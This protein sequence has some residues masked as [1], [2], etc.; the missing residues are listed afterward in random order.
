[1]TINNSEVWNQFVQAANGSNLTFNDCDIYGSRFTASD[2]SSSINV[3]NS[4]LYENPESCHPNT[5]INIATGQP[6]CNPFNKPGFPKIESIGPV[7][8]DNTKNCGTV[9]VDDEVIESINEI[10][11]YPNPFAYSTT[12]DISFNRQTIYQVILIDH[13]GKTVRTYKNVPTR[14]MQ[15]E[16]GTLTSGLYIIQ[17]IVDN[18]LV[19]SKKTIIL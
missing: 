14:K 10:S 6:F 16:K 1:M 4:C 12:L 5:M 3:N 17:I 19:D 7:T 2:N 15:I 13:L 11:I 9:S 18:K 8:Y